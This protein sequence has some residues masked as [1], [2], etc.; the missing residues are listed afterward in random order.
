M[1]NSTPPRVGNSILMPYPHTFPPFQVLNFMVQAEEKHT[2]WYNV[3]VAFCETMYTYSI[4]N[5][6]Q[7]WRNQVSDSGR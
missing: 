6:A 7:L 3:E 5:G 4:Q 2:Q 1:W